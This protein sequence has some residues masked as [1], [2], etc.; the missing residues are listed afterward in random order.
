MSKAPALTPEKVIKIL[1]KSGYLLDR[2]KGSHRIYYHHQSKK[3][4]VVPFHK[5]DL[6]RGTMLEIL[7][8]AG[9]K[10]EDI[11]KTQKQ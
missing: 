3:R 4:V 1:E 11:S 7:K 2:T 8:Q 6:P 9:I 5:G 10:R